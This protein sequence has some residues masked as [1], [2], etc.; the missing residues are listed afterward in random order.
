MIYP[1]KKI[2]RFAFVKTKENLERFCLASALEIQVDKGLEV[3]RQG[4]GALGLDVDLTLR[5]H[6]EIFVQSLKIDLIQEINIQFEAPG[7]S[8]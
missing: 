4:Q 2:I 6:T 5:T 3:D 8:S 7:K 1:F